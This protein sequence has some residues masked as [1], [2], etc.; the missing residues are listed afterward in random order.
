MIRRVLVEHGALEARV[1]AHVL[2]DLLA[3]EAGVSIGG[4]PVEQHPEQFPGTGGK[5]HQ[6]SRPADATAEK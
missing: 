3:H 2:A 6:V 5:S 4:E 1:R